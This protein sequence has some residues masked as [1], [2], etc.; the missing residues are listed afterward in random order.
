MPTVWISCHNICEA[1][2][3]ASNNLKYL[4]EVEKPVGVQ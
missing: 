3:V 1:A 4:Q 2:N